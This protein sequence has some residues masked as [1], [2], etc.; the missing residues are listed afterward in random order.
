MSDARWYAKSARSKVMVKVVW[1]WKLEILPFSKFVFSTIF[2]GSWQLT[3][4]SLTR[5][6]YLKMCLGRIFDIFPSFRVT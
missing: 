1:R 2:H 5:G 6:Q 3:A 4:D